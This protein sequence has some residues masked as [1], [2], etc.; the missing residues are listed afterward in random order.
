M[1]KR[2][3]TSLTIVTAVIMTIGALVGSVSMV[4]QKTYAQGA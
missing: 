1:D 2:L 4:Q 3:V